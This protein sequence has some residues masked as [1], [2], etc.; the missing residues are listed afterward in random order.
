[1][2]SLLSRI[3]KRLPGAGR[4]DAALR[5]HYTGSA[6][7]EAFPRGHYNSPLPDLGEVERRADLLFA[8]DV[9]GVPGVDLRAQAQLELLGQFARYAGEFDWPAQAGE[10]F[11]YHRE[12]PWFEIGDA[13]SLYFVLRHFTPR[14]VV[15]VGSGFSSA[16]MLDVNDRFLDGAVRFTFVEPFPERLH[17]L[18]RDTDRERVRI[19]ETAVQEVPLEAF[20]AL[21]AGDVLF[22][23]S[24][25]VSRIGSDVNR[26]VF[27]VLPRL[28]SGV[29]VHV[30]DVLW[31]FEYPKKWVMRGC[32]W[33]EAYLLRAFLQYNDRFEIALFNSYLAQRHRAALEAVAPDFLESPGGSL[34][35]R[36]R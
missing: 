8:T 32:A 22:V 17:S 9:G 6:R 27:D 18:L 26:L 5:A 1:V 20:E 31:P 12:N 36:A 13:L 30:H 7:P 4:L 21:E 11:R 15:E 14:R 25:H 34:W 23:D 16:L 29:L 35:M 33:N 19:H 2:A 24:S 3:A 10:G 28:A